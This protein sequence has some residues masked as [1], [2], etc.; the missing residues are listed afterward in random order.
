MKSPSNSGHMLAAIACLAC[1][2]DLSE[3]EIPQGDPVVVVQAVMR[4]DRDPQFVVI[5][6]SFIGDEDYKLGVDA[7][8]PWERAAEIPIE[9]AHVAVANVDLPAESCGA[10]VMFES[11]ANPPGVLETA[12]VYW[13]PVACP[14]MRAGDRLTLTV[15]TPTGDT[16]SGTTHLPGMNGAW[17]STGADSLAFGTDSVMLFNRDR[18]VL[19][20]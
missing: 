10:Q 1:G 14:T 11:G 13:S 20:V 16:V 4:P 8:I 2:C 19:R 3:V 15:A 12:G 6:Q 17:F 18:D 5:E 9:G 7:P